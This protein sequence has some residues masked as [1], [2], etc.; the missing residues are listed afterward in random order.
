MAYLVWERAQIQAALD[1]ASVLEDPYLLDAKGRPVIDIVGQPRRTPH[2]EK[3]RTAQLA[4]D[5]AR[6]ARYALRTLL[7]TALVW[8]VVFASYRASEA[9]TTAATATLADC[10][11]RLVESPLQ[12]CLAPLHASYIGAAGDVAG[13]EVMT[14][15]ILIL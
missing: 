9:E 15:A 14:W 3:V 7:A 13:L 10:A 12:A 6:K 1:A 8:C 4:H 11:K 5:N 2:E